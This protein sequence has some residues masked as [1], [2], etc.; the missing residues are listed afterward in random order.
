[1][2]EKTIIGEIYAYLSKSSGPDDIERYGLG[3]VSFFTGAD[4]APYGYTMLG[5]VP[6]SVRI[7]DAKT[8]VDNKVTSLKEE[9]TKILAEAQAKATEIDRKIQTL[10][11]ITYEA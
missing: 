3:A 5:P 2:N 10:L 7:P 8:I 4:M 11:A 1:M 6:V 9:K